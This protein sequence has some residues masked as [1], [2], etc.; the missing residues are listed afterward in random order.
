M[1]TNVMEETLDR[2]VKAV[3]IVEKE[4]EG[5]RKV[6]LVEIE[7]V[8]DREELLEKRGEIRTKEEI[9]VDE[10][11]TME[12]RIENGGEEKK[13]E[14][15]GAHRWTTGSCGSMGKNGN[16]MMRRKYGGRRG[17]DNEGRRE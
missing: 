17:L 13:E 8:E 15:K 4:G 3:R 7:E 16:G 9:E 6:L 10:D 12:K 2:R 11:L 14:K 1:A 5:K